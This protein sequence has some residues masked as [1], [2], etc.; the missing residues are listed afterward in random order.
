MWVDGPLLSFFY[1]SVCI[2]AWLTQ[3]REP[4][5]L[6]CPWEAHT[7]LFG[8]FPQSFH[9]FEGRNDLMWMKLAREC[10]IVNCLL[11]GTLERRKKKL[12]WLLCYFVL[13]NPYNSPRK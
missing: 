1:G 13:F 10:Q 2:W 6:S 7:H 8:D 12:C 9:L 5:T 11:A 3:W 4:D